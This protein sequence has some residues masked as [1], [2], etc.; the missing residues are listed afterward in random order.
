MKSRNSVKE[1]LFL[2]FL[3]GRLNSMDVL[4]IDKNDLYV[5]VMGDFGY[6]E[7]ESEIKRNIVREIKKLNNARKF[8]VGLI[9]GDNSYPL[10]VKTGDFGRME[11]VFSSSFSNDEFNISFFS[12]LGNHDY[13][14]DIRT[15]IEYYSHEPRFYMPSRYF[16][17]HFK[18]SRSNFNISFVCAD[19]NPILEHRMM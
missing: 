7:T 9:L 8:D 6:S 10:G 15:Q 11:E 12:I 13:F 17:K 1:F 16:R 3:I 2:I 4:E 14:G 19:S 5:V 18:V